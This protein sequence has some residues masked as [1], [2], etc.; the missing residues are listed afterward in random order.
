VVDTLL[1]SGDEVLEEV[2]QRLLQAQQVS[3]KY[4]DA[5]HRDEEFQVGDLVWLCLLHRTTQS[6]DPRAKG[7]LGPRYAGPFQITERLGTVAYRLQLPPGSRLHDVFHM[8][9]LK[10]HHGV[11]PAAPGPLPPV[12]DDWLLP[13]PGI[14]LQA[15]QRRC[16][17]H[18][19]IQWQGLPREEAT[20]ESLTEF[21]RQYPDFQLEDELFAQAGRDVMNGTVYHRRKPKSG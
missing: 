4:Y 15:Q 16:E 6:L 1:S 14:A 18:V 9:L 3:K 10:R 13:A 17:W 21:R 20:W 11:P 19:L 8:G 12:L 5:G 2:R 7:K